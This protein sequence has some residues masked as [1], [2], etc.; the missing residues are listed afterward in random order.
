MY[1]LLTKFISACFNGQP[2]ISQK[3]PTLYSVATTG[4]SNTDPTIYG[5]INPFVISYGEVVQIVIN[6]KDE[7]IHP[8]HLHGHQFQIVDRPA[9]G[10][11]DWVKNGDYPA[12]PARRDVVDVMGNSHAVIRFEAT[13]PG[14]FLFHCHIE[15][16]VEMGLTATI[17]VAPDRLR[18][19]KFPADHIHNCEIQDIPIAGNAAGSRSNFTSR[20]GF[21][22]VP[23]PV[24]TG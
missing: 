20:T 1:L 9:S 3:V 17:I 2:Y 4:T 19:I 14:V 8:F 22:T 13:N 18:D 10:S 16:H 15:W 12:Q 6:N 24:Y 21:I 7:A 5:D 11:G 23:D